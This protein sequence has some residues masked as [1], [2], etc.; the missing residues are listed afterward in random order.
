MV[1]GD[2]G[3]AEELTGETIHAVALFGFE[4][5]MGDEGIEEGA[6][7]LDAVPAED[8]EV[9]L[10]IVPDLDDLGMGEDA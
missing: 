4:E 7:D 2:G 5:G 10:K 1:D 8:E 3:V 6:L 9:E